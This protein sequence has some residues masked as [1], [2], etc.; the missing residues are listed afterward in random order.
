MY[1]EARKIDCELITRQ[2]D[3]QHLDYN[4]IH[5]PQKLKV[6]SYVFVFV[7]INYIVLNMDNVFY[8]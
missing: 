2:L 6:N 5:S 3:T 7:E 4:I 8:L 1:I